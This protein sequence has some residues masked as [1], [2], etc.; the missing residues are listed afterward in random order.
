[1]C[2]DFNKNK[3]HSSTKQK[4]NEIKQKFGF[5]KKQNIIHKKITE[6]CNYFV[7]HQMTTIFIFGASIQKFKSILFH[8]LQIEPSV[9]RLLWYSRWFF[10]NR[11]SSVHYTKLWSTGFRIENVWNVVTIEPLW[12]LHYILNRVFILHKKARCNQ[13]SLHLLTQITPP[14]HS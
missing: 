14:N 3:K 5:E 8:L 12:L 9:H 4:L 13:H 6:H 2:V 1:M 10:L 11:T 7:P